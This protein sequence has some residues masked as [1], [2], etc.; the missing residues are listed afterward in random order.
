MGPPRFGTDDD[1]NPITLL[2]KVLK[3]KSQGDADGTAR[4]S[5]SLSQIAYP[6]APWIVNAGRYRSHFDVFAAGVNVHF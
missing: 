3:E 2:P 6:N 5:Q 4:L 1:G